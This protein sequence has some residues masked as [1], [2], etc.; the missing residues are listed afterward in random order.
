MKKILKYVF[1]SAGWLLLAFFL[2]SSYFAKRFDMGNG[3]TGYSPISWERQ[4]DF[5][6]GAIQCSLTDA[7]L[8]ERKELIQ[9]DLLSRLDRKEEVAN[10]FVFYF[11]DEPGLLE[12]AME[13]VAKE[14]ACCPFFKFDISVLPF[15]QGIAL[16]LSGAPG[17]VDLI[18]EF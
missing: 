17:A 3:A 4:V 8:L 10:G 7:E 6:K 11:K 12:L 14:K 1:F 13:F 18:R 16:G 15:N 5:F 9:A 2:V